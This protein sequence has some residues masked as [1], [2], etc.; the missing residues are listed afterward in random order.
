MLAMTAAWIGCRS[1]GRTIARSRRRRPK[2]EEGTKYGHN[3]NLNNLVQ[4]I[5][6]VEISVLVLSIFKFD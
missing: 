5:Q 4:K 6:I 2:S 3:P 1:W